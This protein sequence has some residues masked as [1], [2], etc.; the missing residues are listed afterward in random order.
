MANSHKSRC[1]NCIV[2]QLN[3]LKALS[4]EDLKSISD[5]KSELRIAKGNPLFEEGKQL[6]GVYCVRSGASKLSKLN[7]DGREHIVKIAP[8]GEVLGKRSLLSEEKAALSVHALEDMEVCFIPKTEI[9]QYLENNPQFSQELLKK[10]AQDLKQ[11]Q[12]RATAFAQKTVIQRLSGTLLY[13][14]QESGVDKDGYIALSISREDLASFVGT[15]TESCI[16]L[17]GK[18]K[19]DKIITTSAKRIKILDPTRLEKI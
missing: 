9:N 8:R 15:A 5:A 2:R 14:Q 7:E 17:I 18:L 4:K 1:E 19:R 16:R 6:N 10:F 3:E 11:S 13:L 12:K